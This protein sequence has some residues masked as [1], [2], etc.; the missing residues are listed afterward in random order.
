[1]TMLEN[2]FEGSRGTERKSMSKA[3]PPGLMHPNGRSEPIDGK[4]STLAEEPGSWTFG[5]GLATVFD[6][7]VQR[8]IPGY[9]ELHRKCIELVQLLVQPGDVI[10]DLGSS[11]GSLTEQLHHAAPGARVI[12]IDS[13]PE[14]VNEARRR[15]PHIEFICESVTSPRLE[16]AA[17]TLALY[18]LQFTP[19]K[20]RLET[21]RQIRRSLTPS[22]VFIWAEKVRYE[23]QGEQSLVDAAYR[24]FKRDQ[25]FTEA[26]IEEKA[27]SLVGVLVPLTERENVELLEKAGFRS[28]EPLFEDLCFRAWVAHT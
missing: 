2:Q 26:E 28:I 1:M 15:A 27:R 5:N 7:H 25:G 16:Q 23:D 13:E 12:G 11:T 10:Y 19:V 22:G 18:V 24:Q 9:L 6:D 8:S 14:M 21:L 20:T 3:P 4:S 17:V